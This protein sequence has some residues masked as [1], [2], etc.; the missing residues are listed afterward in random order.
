MSQTTTNLIELKRQYDAVKPYV[1]GDFTPRVGKYLIYAVTS[2]SIGAFKGVLIAQA[3]WSPNLG[4]LGKGLPVEI[5][6]LS[7]M[8]PQAMGPEVKWGNE[9]LDRTIEVNYGMTK[10]IIDANSCYNIYVV[11]WRFI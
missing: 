4:E 6:L 11:N 10:E 3:L 1:N 5:Q 2:Q 9:F 8:H 7:L